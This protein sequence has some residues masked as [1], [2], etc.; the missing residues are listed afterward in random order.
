MTGDRR[1][2]AGV[3]ALSRHC[4]TP[5]RVTDRLGSGHS[6]L[7]LAPFLPRRLRRR[8]STS[9]AGIHQ[10]P[11][12]IRLFDETRRGYMQMAGEPFH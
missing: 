12:G 10:A 1:A 4:A 9:A 5:L 8:S 11:R 2:H 6:S 3:V 7:L